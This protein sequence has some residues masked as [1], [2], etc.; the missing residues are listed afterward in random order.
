MSDSTV[1]GK[2]VFRLSRR[3]SLSVALAA[4]AGLLFHITGTL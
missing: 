2:I 3:A 4:V 1:Y